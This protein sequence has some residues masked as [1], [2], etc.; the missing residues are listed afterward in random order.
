M[1]AVGEILFQCAS[2]VSRRDI[3]PQ[4]EDEARVRIGG[5]GVL[6]DRRRRRSDRRFEL[7]KQYLWV[8][9]FSKSSTNTRSRT[10]VDMPEPTPDSVHKLGK[11]KQL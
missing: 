6:E 7:N 8:I 1:K 10:K 3:S 2:T 5:M 4:I 9:P 11:G